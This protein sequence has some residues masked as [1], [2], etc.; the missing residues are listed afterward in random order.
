MPKLRVVLLAAMLVTS[1][2]GALCGPAF[3]ADAERRDPNGKTGISPYAEALHRGDVAA[4]RRSFDEAILQYQ[5]AVKLN[6]SNPAALYRIGQAQV[7]AGHL[8]QAQ[9]FYEHALALADS[10]PT[11]KAKILFVLA[12]M[13]ER[14]RDLARAITAW[15]GYAEYLKGHQAAHGYPKTAEERIARLTKAQE[16]LEQYAKVRERIKTRLDL[17][18]QSAKESAK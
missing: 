18:E 8:D 10:Q 6:P 4:G 3:G 13:Q 16:L 2:M 12:D 11:L 1:G 15:K 5:Q 14:R 9:P 17:A 7:A